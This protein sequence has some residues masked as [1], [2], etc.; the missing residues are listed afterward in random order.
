MTRQRRVRAIRELKP[1]L[2]RGE[3]IPNG[4]AQEASKRRF[5]MRMGSPFCRHVNGRTRSLPTSTSLPQQ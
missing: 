4:L 2:V 3:L 1:A 5:L